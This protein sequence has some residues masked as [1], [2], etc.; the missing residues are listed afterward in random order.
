MLLSLAAIF[1]PPAAAAP[2]APQEI[3]SWTDLETALGTDGDYIL[4][5]DV[6]PENAFLADAL[7]VPA[8]VTAALD[9]N[10]H[11]VDRGY[12]EQGFDGSVIKIYGTLT[13][14]DSAAGGAITGGFPDQFGGGVQIQG[15]T[16]NLQGGSITGNSV[17]TT[18]F[19]GTEGLGGGVYMQSGSFNMSGGT[20]TGNEAL[21]SS[22]GSSLGRGGGVYISGGTF[23]FT[24]GTISGN[25]AGI[26]GGGVYLASTYSGHDGKINVAGGATVAGNRVGRAASNVYLEEGGVLTV[27]GALTGTIGVIMP[28]PGVFTSG[29][30]GNG[31][32]EN[33]TSDDTSYAVS[34]TDDGEAQL[35]PPPPAVTDVVATPTGGSWEGKVD[36]SFNVA[37]SP[38]GAC[39]DWNAPFLSIVATDHATGSNY[40]AAASALSGDTD[41]ADGPHA[42]TWDMGAQGI[43]MESTNVTFTV[44]Y[45]KMPDWCVLDLSGNGESGGPGSV[46]AIHYAVSYLDAPP[47]GGFTNDLYKTDKLAM[48][49]VAPEAD[50]AR[51]FYCAVFETTQRQWELVT[52]GRPSHFTNETCYATRPV[53]KVSWSMI[54]GDAATYDWPATNAVDESS[55]LGLLRAR[56]GLSALDLPTEAQWEFA[57]RAG[58][59]TDF[60]NGKNWTGAGD[61]AN[62]GEVARYRYNGGY[63]N[64]VSRPDQG[65]AADHGTAAVGS[66]KPN[67]WGLYDM[68]GNVF[69][70][71]LDRYSSSGSGRVNRG[72]CWYDS[73][74]YCTSSGRINSSPSI[75]IYYYGFRLVRTL[76]NDLEGERSAEAAAGA[77]RVGTVCAG[78]SAPVALMPPPPSKA[79]LAAEIAWKC[80]KAT[81]TY[82]AQLKVTCTNGLAAGVGDLRF[83]FADRIGEDGKTEA[84]LWSTPARAANPNMEYVDGE[85]F[86]FVPLDASLIAEENVPATFGVSDRASATVPVAERTIEL[87]VH[88]RV[89]PQTGNEGAAKVGNFVGYVS[90]TSGGELNAVPVV[91]DPRA[92]GAF[93]FAGRS[94]GSATLLSPKALNESLAVGVPIAEGS[95]PYCRL[96][97]FAIDGDVMRGTVEVG[98]GA[99]AGALGA[100]ATVTLLGAAAPGGP[101]A[102][103][104]AVAVEG[105]GAFS[106]AKPAGC[107]FFK[108]RLDIEEVV[109]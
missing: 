44:A 98:A 42:V 97:A 69:E 64:G 84:A 89:V 16:F 72:G 26:L 83:M 56:T 109:K 37:N 103:L 107:A 85:T 4:T 65:C 53:E 51:P 24:G 73:A 41:A 93:G 108:L 55:F 100:N 45:L 52:G 33:F 106:L 99:R 101:F 91:A 18:G 77:E 27:D 47:A 63:V 87:Y 61:D 15:G 68:H 59:T 32:K 31:T 86:R 19:F 88:R 78:T 21:G 79:E 92:A 25:E 71:C 62:L 22:M 36:I 48:R 7:T 43:A 2:G 102:E 70:W 67:A 90:W 11:T 20:I 23:N 39:P 95:S 46:P 40:V 38:A 82:F 49:L 12:R 3:S 66:Y 96:T 1:A 13:L 74:G 94:R 5:A 6:A 17:G 50:G 104:G 76:S 81:G 54:R 58:T 80:L 105:D 28:T 9:L 57:C 75:G 35:A 10:G 60:N 29:L 14:M 34:L 30:S 8:D